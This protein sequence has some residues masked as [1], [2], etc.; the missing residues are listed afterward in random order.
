MPKIDADGIVMEDLEYT[1]SNGKSWY[2]AG[3]IDVEQAMHLFE[4]SKRAREGEDN[5]QLIKDL[6]RVVRDLF[7]TRHDEDELQDLKIPFARLLPVTM[8]IV[9]AL[10]SDMGELPPQEGQPA[11][12]SPKKKRAKSKKKQ[13]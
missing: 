6:D 9:S 8:G 5:I 11:D 12:K 1:D 2:I 7:A 10:T 3:D 4:M 13:S